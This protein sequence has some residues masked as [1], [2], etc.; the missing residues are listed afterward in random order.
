MSQKVKILRIRVNGHVYLG[1]HLDADGALSS[2]FSG[3][4]SEVAQWLC[5]G[6]RTRF[7]QHRS[8]RSRW[9]TT[10]GPDV[11]C[12]D[13][14]ARVLVSI[15]HSV[16]SITDAQARRQFTY[17]AAMPT[18]VIQAQ[19]KLE[20]TQWFAAARRRATNRAAGRRGGAMP[21]FRS[22]KHSDDTF[23]CWFNGGRN[24]V[25][26]KTGKRSGM[27]TITGQNPT[28]YAAAG[29]GLRWSVT[30]H[31][32]L[33][34]PIREY[35]SVR[36]NWTRKDL[37]FINVPLPVTGRVT[38][39]EVRGYD[40]GVR[41]ALADSAGGFIDAPDVSGLIKVRKHHQ[42]KMAKSKIVAGQQGRQF[43]ASRGYQ[44][45]K[46]AAAEVAAKIA[47]VNSDWRQQTSTKIVRGSD[48][49]VFEEL[50]LANMTRRAKG[51]RA[52]QKRGLNRG[53]LTAGLGALA[54]LTL[55]KAERSD[56]TYLSINPAYTSQR[57]NKCA[58]IAK[59]NRESQAGFRC[60][61]CG[62]TANADTN[63]ARNILD[64]GLA[65]WART[66][67]DVGSRIKTGNRATGGIKASAKTA[68]A[69]NHQPPAIAA[70]LP[71]KGILALQG[72]E[73]VNSDTVVAEGLPPNQGMTPT[74]WPIPTTGTASVGNAALGTAG[75][76]RTVADLIL[77]AAIGAVR[78]RLNRVSAAGI[79]Q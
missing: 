70:Q 69:L 7:N 19:Q 47:R 64:A 36:I 26:V 15:G 29:H 75:L 42:R 52:S 11:N 10:D 76:M 28:G 2:V 32:R 79:R 50:K 9:E 68:P 38:S 49:V 18:Y 65:K 55:Q 78:A 39:G 45:H 24:A 48:L 71:V 30:V 67:A 12:E 37:V 16:T 62:H 40:R 61:K 21:T 58:H 23:A 14:A 31:V 44:R 4:G 1:D 43:F 3:A 6:S 34:Q 46:A 13:P 77:D 51:A 41:R 54:D 22:R 63:A 17:L 57:C 73:D 74:V 5:D 56:V 59:G 25:F 53:L 72:G 27:V 33:S 66:K 8:N 35:T 20:A 60:L